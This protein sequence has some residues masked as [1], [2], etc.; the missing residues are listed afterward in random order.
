[1]KLHEALLNGE[2]IFEPIGVENVLINY[3]F[4]FFT[5]TSIYLW[6]HWSYL[7]KISLTTKINYLIKE[8]T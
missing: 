1:M 7:R 2:L 4:H 3:F 6:L 8:R 5:F